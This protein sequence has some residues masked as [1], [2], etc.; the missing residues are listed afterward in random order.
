MCHESELSF[1]CWKQWNFGVLP[2]RDTIENLQLGHRQ[3]V[4][5]V[6]DA[7]REE[8]RISGVVPTGWLNTQSG[9]G[10][11]GRAWL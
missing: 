11:A 3:C 8:A 2:R 6:R 7:E 1:C 5:A 4:S 9:L 10:K